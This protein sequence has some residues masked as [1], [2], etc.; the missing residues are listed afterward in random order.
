M[1]NKLTIILLLCLAM[2]LTAQEIQIPDDIQLE[3][4]KDFQDH[5]KLVLQSIEW[6]QNTPLSQN[7]SKRREINAFLMKWMSGTPSI[8]IELV[9]GLVPLE[10]S[11][12]L[13]LFMSGWTKYSIENN[14]SQDKLKCALAGV[15]MTVAFYEKNK[16][17]LGKKSEME[18]LIKRKKKGKL[19]KYVAAQY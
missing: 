15:E 18:K 17:E 14:Y 10:C 13:M 5:E 9:S 4:K 3:S 19:E 11:E 16:S 2:N 1:K 6:I 8:T 7:P 12:C